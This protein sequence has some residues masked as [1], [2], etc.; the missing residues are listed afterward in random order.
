L[1]LPCTATNAA[2][3][4]GIWSEQNFFRTNVVASVKLLTAAGSSAVTGGA[5]TSGDFS[6]GASVSPQV[7]GGGIVNFDIPFSVAFRYGTNNSLSV[8]GQVEAVVGS[9]GATAGREVDAVFTNGITWGGGRILDTQ[10][11]VVADASVL[12]ASGFNYAAVSSVPEPGEFQMLFAGLAVLL[13]GLH[14]R[15]LRSWPTYHSK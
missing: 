14:R 1:T 3:P 15:R 10:G 6:H 2:V 8:F 12:S 7:G 9:F 5:G 4:C 13:S 11:Q